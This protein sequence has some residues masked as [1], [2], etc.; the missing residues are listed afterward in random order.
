MLA[1]SVKTKPADAVCATAL[2]CNCFLKGT[3]IR[4]PDGDKRIEDL[5][6][7][8]LL[9]TVFGG[10][11]PIQW[12]GR[13]RF[14]KSDPTKAWPKD[15]VPIR[16]ARSALGPNVPHADLF[17]TK[18][19]ALLIDDVLVPVCNL[20]NSSTITLYDA[21][22]LDE[23]EFFHI[24]LE[25]HDVIYAEGAPCETLLNVDENAF[26]FSEYLRQNGPPIFRNAPCAPVLGF[27]GRVE[28]KSRFRSAISPW[29]DR[30]QKLDIIR[31][32][33][34]EGEI[35]LLRQSELTS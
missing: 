14:K 3:T 32:K 8:D 10:V 17:V 35:A 30:R 9:P 33:L 20:I 22:G 7:G 5:A 16:V 27:G 23:L 26:N 18:A 31:D 11:R 12:I 4:T 6:E 29:I 34:E 15:V 2:G 28:I 19:H 1:I 25:L 13:Y 21:R 24:K